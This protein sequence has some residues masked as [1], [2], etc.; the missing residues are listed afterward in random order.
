MNNPSNI[1]ALGEAATP[2]REPMTSNLPGGSIPESAWKD[3]ARKNYEERMRQR[4]E[5][6][7][8]EKLNFYKKVAKVVIAGSLAVTA[9]FGA[10]QI[11]KAFNNQVPETDLGTIYNDPNGFSSFDSTAEL[12]AYC[13]ENGIDFASLQY[14]LDSAGGVVV[15]NTSLGQTNNHVR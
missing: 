4:D 2:R 10:S 9:I 7:K 13:E 14:N 6:K 3:V 11:Y 8:E 12:S 5:I 1:N 15:S